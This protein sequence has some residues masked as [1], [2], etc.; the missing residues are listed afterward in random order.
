M[1]AIIGYV[2][3]VDGVFA[4]TNTNF[5]MAISAYKNKL[6]SLYQEYSNQTILISSH[7]GITRNFIYSIDPSLRPD[8]NHI[9]MSKFHEAAY[10]VLDY[11]GQ[12]FIVDQ[13]NIGCQ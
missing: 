12:K 10:A 9:F 7:G 11:D 6:T 3:Y 13:F 8:D 5:N 1:T 2:V 4:D